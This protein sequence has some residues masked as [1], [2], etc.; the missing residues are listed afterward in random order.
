MEGITADEYKRAQ[1]MWSTYKC[2]NMQDFHNVYVKLDVVLLAD[3]METFGR[4]GMQEYGIDLAHCWTL[5]GYTW[6]CH[7][8]SLA[9]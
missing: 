7:L 3:C 5:A 6:Q 2:E 1:E 9:V 4:V 8:T